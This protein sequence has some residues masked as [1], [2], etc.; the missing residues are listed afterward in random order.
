MTGGLRLQA[1]FRVPTTLHPQ[2]SVELHPLQGT[3]VPQDCSL[4]LWIQTNDKLFFDPYELEDRW[5]A[6]S[7]LSDSIQEAQAFQKGGRTTGPRMWTVDPVTP[8]LE[9]PV[10]YGFRSS[11]Q[12]DDDTRRE[13]RLVENT[14]YM[15]M[16][17]VLPIDVTSHSSLEWNVPSHARY[18]QPCQ[19]G[20]HSV[21]I[22]GSDLSTPRNESSQLANDV[23][24]L[25]VLACQSFHVLR[26]STPH[27]GHDNCSLPD[28]AIRSTI[29][30]KIS[31]DVLSRRFAH[32]S[33]I[34]QRIPTQ[35]HLYQ[36]PWSPKL[37]QGKSH[38]IS[39]PAAV[40]SQQSM[41]ALV[42]PAVVMTCSLW[43]MYTLFS[44]WRISARKSQSKKA[45]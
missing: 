37:S 14:L 16:D 39:L 13:E 36:I 5:P 11:Q 43:I 2:V 45:Q 20:Y 32:D 33:N 19:D 34:Q 15:Y 24:V 25:A 30:T 41:V 35:D 17:H 10:K 1:G 42:T 28:D 23:D 31:K 9:R 38:S 7:D 44:M 26:K 3:S 27:P 29:A 18:L 8:D 4:H 21:I 6:E 12:G 40:T 22:G